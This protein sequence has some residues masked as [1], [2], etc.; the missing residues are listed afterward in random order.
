MIR[1]PPIATLTD[2]LFPYTTLF[3]SRV[4][5]HV[6]VIVLTG[7]DEA[8]GPFQRRRDHVVDQAMLVGQALRLE[9]RGELL[10]EDLLE[11][12]LEAAVIVFED[13]VL[14][15]QIDRIAALEAVIERRA[16]R[17]EEHTS[18]LQSLMRITY[19]VFHL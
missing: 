14:G 9:L 19:A 7:P 18:E 8:A 4:G 6:A 3:R 1:L 11:D 16:G 2:T 15:R 5:R 17:S 12:V 13:R 10:V